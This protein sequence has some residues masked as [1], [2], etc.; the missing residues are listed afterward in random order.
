M[1]RLLVGIV[2]ALVV[3]ITNG[4]LMRDVMAK[5]AVMPDTAPSTTS[6]AP[7]GHGLRSETVLSLALA[8]EALRATPVLLDPR[9]N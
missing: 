5:D 4:G 3:L 9:R 8:L 6:Q 7:V 2:I 1:D